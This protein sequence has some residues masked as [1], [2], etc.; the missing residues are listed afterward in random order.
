MIIIGEKLNS[1]LK[2]I[3]PAMESRDKQAIQ[4]LA[5]RQIHAGA[6]FID[7]NA[8]MFHEVESEVLKWLIETIQEVT[9]VPFAI[10]SPS[11]SAILSGLQ[12]NK[13]TVSQ[14]LIPSRP[15]RLAM[16]PSFL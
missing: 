3:R 15:K 6:D 5:L 1:T 7:V 2:S 16:M 11:A 8:G 14:S 9:D 4:D 12:A 13:K 10:D